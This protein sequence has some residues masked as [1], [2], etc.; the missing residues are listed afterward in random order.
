MIGILLTKFRLFVRKP[1]LFIIMTATCILFAFFI[2]KGSGSKVE[3]PIFNELS[4]EEFTPFL[5]ELNQSDLFAFVS[6]KEKEMKS[7]V[8]EGKVEAGL[9]IWEDDFQLIITS[10]STNVPLLKQYV[11]TAFT[12]KLQKEQLL[13]SFALKE[14]RLRAEKVWERTLEESLFDVHKEN[15]RNGE[16]RVI[17]NQLQGI[18]GFSLFFVIYTIAFNVV[19][20]LEEKQD[21]I[22]DRMI[23][24]SVKKWEMY[25]GNLLYSFITGYF[26]VVL[27]FVAFHYGAGVDFHGGFGKT[28]I[29]LIPYVLAIVALC[30][31]L[32]GLSKSTRHYNALMQIL[33]VSMA[34]LGGA[35][36]PIEIVSSKFMLLLGKCTPLL[37]GMESLKGATIYGYTYMTLLQPISVLLLMAVVMMGVG[38]TVMERRNG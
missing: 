35:Y 5:D 2:G 14:E 8:R 9:H 4:D 29:I 3:V 13:H 32:A 31:L 33:S 25:V 15:F 36:W 34:M 7:A 10:Q 24:S 16:T 26:Q 12:K 22:W 27:I 21:R 11:Q 20:I 30:M 17:D 1:W 19:H 18:F 37:Y 38:I 23:V 6:M 28:L